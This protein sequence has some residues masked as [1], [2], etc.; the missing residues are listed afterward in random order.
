MNCLKIKT[1][2]NFNFSEC[3]WF[4]DRGFDECIHQVA[5]GKV[6]KLFEIDKQLVL[7]EVSHDGENLI[8]ETLKGELKNQ[9]KLV[10]I[11]TNW[12]DLGRDLTQ[13]YDILKQDADL[14]FL[15]E[16]TLVFGLWLFLIF[17]SDVLEY[18]WATNQPYFCLQNQKG[19][20]RAFWRI[21]RI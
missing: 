16:N 17:R 8:I 1:P 18:N 10:E 9:E 19:F 4:L 6:R 11:V 12:F 13:F 20:G 2:L 15:A 5:N 21:F 7:V 3:L 14:V